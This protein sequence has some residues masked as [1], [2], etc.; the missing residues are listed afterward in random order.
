MNDGGTH[1]GRWM[2]LSGGP[3]KR[4]DPGVTNVRNTGSP[5]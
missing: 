1:L 5:H 2:P 4:V 3:G